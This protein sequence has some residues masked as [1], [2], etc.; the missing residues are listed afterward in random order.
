MAAEVRKSPSL[1]GVSGNW[2]H[3]GTWHERRRRPRWRRP[4]SR[5]GTSRRKPRPF[6]RGRGSPRGPSGS[7]AA[8]RRSPDCA[9]VST[10]N[11]WNRAAAAGSFVTSTSTPCRFAS[12]TLYRPFEVIRASTSPIPPERSTSFVSN[13]SRSTG[14]AHEPTH[15]SW[16]RRSQTGL[17]PPEDAAC[18][19]TQPARLATDRGEEYGGALRVVP[20]DE[21]SARRDQDARPVHCAGRHGRSPR[22]RFGH[23]AARAADKSRLPAVLEARTRLVI[24]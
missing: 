16:Q 6:V 5:P 8:P 15:I 13:G 4:G 18:P 23:C 9:A 20:G 3:K 17:D 14:V 2:H 22:L 12:P 7:R 21:W 11:G 10:S 24:A 1:R 19:P